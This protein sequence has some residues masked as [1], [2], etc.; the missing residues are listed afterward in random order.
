MFKMIDIA[1]IP[2]E[3]KPAYDSFASDLTRK[4]REF[5]HENGIESELKDIGD[6]ID[7]TPMLVWEHSRHNMD[8]RRKHIAEA[9]GYIIECIAS[10]LRVST[11]DLYPVVM[12]IE[13]PEKYDQ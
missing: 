1:T 4:L 13:Y 7:K 9:P 10:Y 8:R 12:A 5:F 11:S 3:D 2:A 6:C